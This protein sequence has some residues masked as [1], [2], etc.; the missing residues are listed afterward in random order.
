MLLSEIAEEDSISMI[1]DRNLIGTNKNRQGPKP[2]TSK[3][4]MSM[5]SNFANMAKAEIDA[6]IQQLRQSS[7]NFISG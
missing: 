7:N 4:T 1:S 5:H 3:S 2:E 6:N